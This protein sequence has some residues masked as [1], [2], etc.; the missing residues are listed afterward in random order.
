ML[1]LLKNGQ[2]VKEE[3]RNSK[4]ECTK[5][6]QQLAI[7]DKDLK[8]TKEE[9]AK[10][11]EDLKQAK[12]D[13]VQVKDI[14]F[15]QLQLDVESL[16]KLKQEDERKQKLKE[17]ENRKQQLKE[18]YKVELI[19]AREPYP[20]GFNCKLIFNFYSFANYIHLES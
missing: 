16:I 4:E 14:L 9:L 17:D 19:K 11:N 10:T 12:Q 5:V 20:K 15:K 3:L 13:C 7:T 6:K 2:E 1:L 8:H 18:N